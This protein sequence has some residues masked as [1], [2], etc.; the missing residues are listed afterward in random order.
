MGLEGGH[1]LLEGWGEGG[2]DGGVGEGVCLFSG[3]IPL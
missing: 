2:G 3:K 1:P